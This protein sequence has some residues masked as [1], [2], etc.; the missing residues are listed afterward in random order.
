MT[1]IY[2]IPEQVLDQMRSLVRQSRLGGSAPEVAHH[3]ADDLLCLLL[4][5]LGHDAVVD[6]FDKVKKWYA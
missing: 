4:R 6:E 3:Q 2:P 5:Y 1:D